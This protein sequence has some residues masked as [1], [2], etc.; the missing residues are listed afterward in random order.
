MT[1]KGERVLN[2]SFGGN[3]RSTVFEQID[4]GNINNLK[5]AI[6]TDIRNFFPLVTLNSVDVYATPNFNT[7]R[8]EVNYSVVN[9]GIE[10]TIQLT[11]T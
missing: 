3:L 6:S 10:D 8:V 4:E 11:L 1:N 9:F 7:L 5:L 2:N